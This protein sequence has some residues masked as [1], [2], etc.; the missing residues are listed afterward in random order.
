MVLCPVGTGPLDIT[1]KHF[2]HAGPTKGLDFLSIY[3]RER[4]RIRVGSSDGG[5]F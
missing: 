5:D 4:R 2:I 3:L 1:N